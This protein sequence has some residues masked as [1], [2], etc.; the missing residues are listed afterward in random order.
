MIFPFLQFRQTVTQLRKK[1]WSIIVLV[2]IGNLTGDMIYFHLLSDR[3]QLEFC[4]SLETIICWLFLEQTL[5][6]VGLMPRPDQYTLRLDSV[7]F[8]C[9]C[10]LR[11]LTFPANMTKLGRFWSK[12]SKP[13]FSP[14]SWLEFH[15]FYWSSS[16]ILHEFHHSRG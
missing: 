15:G 2:F 3:I 7:W 16:S 12:I 5:I 14:C 13:S 8:Y 6:I 10:S 4:T 9:I 1:V 11:Q